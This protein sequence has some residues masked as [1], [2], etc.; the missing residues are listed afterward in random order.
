MFTGIIEYKGVVE[1]L[2]WTN[3]IARLH[4]KAPDA[5]IEQ[6]NIGDSIAVDGVCLTVVQRDSATFQ[7]DVIPETLSRTTIRSWGP[8]RVVNLELPCRP[9]TLLGGH[10]VQGHVDGV[11]RLMEI[12]RFGEAIEH[13]YSLPEAWRVYFVEKGSVAIN[14]VSLTIAGVDNNSF[15]IALIPATLEKTNLGQLAPGDLVNVE[16]DVIAKYI[17]HLMRPYLE[18]SFTS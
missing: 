4:I 6:L 14:G 9:E 2:D 18:Q 8:G 15:R 12:K 3:G 11:T 13:I 7:V 16:V 17:Y 10:L 1:A 5:V